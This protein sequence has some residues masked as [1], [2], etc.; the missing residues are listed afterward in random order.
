MHFEKNKSVVCER[1]LFIT[2]TLVDLAFH[3]GSKS[4]HITQTSSTCIS[5]ELIRTMTMTRWEECRG[6]RTRTDRGLGRSREGE[7]RGMW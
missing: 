6:G 2:T 5:C 3:S 1:I 7:G 4:I